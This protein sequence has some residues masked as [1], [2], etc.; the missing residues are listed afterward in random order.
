[1]CPSL[2]RISNPRWAARPDGDHPIP[3]IVMRHNE[4]GTVRDV[5]T[6]GPLPLTEIAFLIQP[7]G[8]AGHSLERVCQIP[9][10]LLPTERGRPDSH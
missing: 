9:V 3:C 6:G 7:A 10:E 5:L 4:D 2:C 8:Q 1:M